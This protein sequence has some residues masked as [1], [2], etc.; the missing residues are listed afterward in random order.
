MNSVSPDAHGIAVLILIGLALFLFTRDRIPLE[1]SSLAVLITLVAGFELFPYEVDGQRLG[2]RHF[3]S[4]FGHEALIAIC[5]LIMIGKALDLTG[6]LQ[7]LAKVVGYSWAR[8]PALAFLM[9]LVAVAV[10]SAFV[11]DTPIVVLMIPILVAIAMR[12]DKPVTGILLPMGLATIIGGMSTTIGTST[13]L[14][15]VGIAHDLGLPEITMFEFTLPALIVGSV[16]LLYVWQVVPRLLP[17]RKPS[18]IETVPRVF[19]AQLWIPEGSESVGLTLA[20]VRARTD[21]K[22]RINRIQRGENLFVSKLPS[23]HLQAGDRLHVR[24]TPANLKRFEKLLGATLYNASGDEV[25]PAGDTPWNSEDQQLAE[26]VVHRGSPLYMRTIASA[27]LGERSGLL[28]LAIHRAGSAGPQFEGDLGQ[29]RLHGGDV[30]LV[31]GSRKAIEA[32]KRNAAMLVV[33]G[34]TDLP[35]QHRAKR[36]LTVL[37]LV[38]LT[39]ALG[40][41]PIAIAALIGFGMLLVL[42]CLTWRDAAAALPTSVIMIIVTSLA[43]GKALVGTGM[44]EFVA[45]AFV[46]LASGLPT[47]VILSG[48][49]LIVAVLTNIVS[50]NASAVIGTP[51]AVAA[52]EQLGV[53]PV[54]FVLAVLFGANM[55]F[56]TPFGYQTNLLIMSAAG[57]RFADF[58][59][60]GV[61]LIFIMWLGFSLV[62][63]AF[64]NLEALPTADR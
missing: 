12:T 21:G 46:A 62:L 14:L 32:L 63:P 59:R 39:A 44:A 7:P 29:L 28:P 1:T 10:L 53:N 49:M 38:I 37:A 2:P 50:N 19:N 43:L 58:L 26:I 17:E 11:N 4:G 56:A 3:V 54:P 18:M 61:P 51:I 24:D 16:G 13:N 33:D 8:K 5:S 60:A 45:G 22:L 41:L 64:Y 20:E 31:Q 36:A 55:S 42:G 48:F 35:R 9:M 30:L 34:T 23:I 52:A 40:L 47:P 27:K 25:R 6:A 57:Y 15:V